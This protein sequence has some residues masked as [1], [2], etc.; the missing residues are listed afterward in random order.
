MRNMEENQYHF[1]SKLNQISS[2]L[3]KQDVDSY[4]ADR[5]Y[6][7]L[8]SYIEHLARKTIPAKEFDQ[9]NFLSFKEYSK[10]EIKKSLHT[11]LFSSKL[12]ENDRNPVPY[13]K[14]CLKRMATNLSND[15]KNIKLSLIM[16]CPLCLVDNKKSLL[17]P[18]TGGDFHWKCLECSKNTEAY[19]DILKKAILEKDQNLICETQAKLRASSAFQLHSRKGYCCPDCKRFIPHSTRTELGIS[20]PYPDCF[21]FGESSSLEPMNHPLALGHNPLVTISIDESVSN[22]DCNGVK[23]KD[24]IGASIDVIK[25]QIL[26]DDY[27][28]AKQ[29]S[30]KEYSVLINSIDELIVFTKKQSTPATKKQKV[31]ML[32][33]YKSLSKKMPEDMI[34]YL[35]HRKQN[36]EI[37]LQSKIFQEYTSLIENA[38]P[39][40]IKKGK[41]QNLILS[42][43]DENLN[44][45]LGQSQFDSVVGVDGFIPNETKEIYIG[46]RTH[47]HYGP[48]FIGKIIDIINLETNQSILSEVKNYSFVGVNL[49]ERVRVGTRVRVIHFRI[50]PH[51]ETMGLVFLQRMRRQ[52]VDKVY[53]K[54]NKKKRIAK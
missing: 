44:L 51:Y 39:F 49:N 8:L 22:R 13:I 9:L 54:L 18:P 40:S 25:N 29:E 45:F 5:A 2:V 24:I 50:P 47:K 33:A 17:K 4:V 42:L 10:E 20:C 48:C 3:T 53:F 7:E 19:Q 26:Q 30:E 41:D 52:I 32:E 23:T 36:S 46:D 21:F 28:Q 37:P 38:L 12:W 14:L 31:L 15:R 34:S 6:E 43:T 35:V 1:L 11:Y 27:L 16:T